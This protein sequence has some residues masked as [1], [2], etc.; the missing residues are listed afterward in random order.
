MS[1][2]QDAVTKK[3]CHKKGKRKYFF[4]KTKQKFLQHK[5]TLQQVNCT[6]GESKDTDLS[7]KSGSKKY[8][9]GFFWCKF[10]CQ[11]STHF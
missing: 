4:H 11:N 2:K 6:T 1:Q 9:T 10:C 3:K 5:K 8:I 7:L